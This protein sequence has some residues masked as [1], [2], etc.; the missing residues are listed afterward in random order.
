MVARSVPTSMS[1]ELM[2]NMN[3]YGYKKFCAV[4]A[5]CDSISLEIFKASKWVNYFA[6][7][8]SLMFKNGKVNPDDVYE[9]F[10]N[11]NG[12]SDRG[13]RSHL[14]EYIYEN[15]NFFDHRGSVCLPLRGLGLNTWV[16][17]VKDSHVCCDELAL[18]GLSA[19]YQ[20]HSLVVT[21]TKFWSTIKSEQ[22]L[23]IITLKKECSVRLLYLGNMKFGTLRWQPHNPQPV[24]PK[25][26]LGKFNIIEEY[27]LDEQTA[28]E[29][30]TAENNDAKHV[31]T[32]AQQE[33]N[34]DVAETGI[35]VSCSPVLP[36][37]T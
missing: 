10:G 25:P 1:T 3:P 27:T 2:Q 14:L 13:V 9:L 33:P 17:N 22:P 19:M 30:S 8:T 5:E 18:L 37:E 4:F 29:S 24:L 32:T 7:D 23:N 12:L 36:E 35:C 11:F 20:R 34:Q 31:E 6:L 16:D 28:G 15:I 21:K 26:N